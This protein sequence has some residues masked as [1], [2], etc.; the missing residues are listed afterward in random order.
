MP[1]VIVDA[2]DILAG[3]VA[4][5]PRAGVYA[6]YSRIKIDDSSPALF[7][8]SISDLLA[9]TSW[10][11]VEKPVKSGKVGPYQVTA[12]LSPRKRKLHANKAVIASAL[13]TNPAGRTGFKQLMADASVLQA[14]LYVGR[15]V[16]LRHRILNQ[17]LKTQTDFSKWITKYL[18][19]SDLVLGYVEMTPLPKETCQVVESVLGTLAL[20]RYALKIG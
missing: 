6:W 2:Q 20:P 17:H 13:S 14:P 12:S 5:P 16:Q 3:S 11:P 9:G 19:L 4:I 15:T 1:A 10:I 7:M 8:K 18:S